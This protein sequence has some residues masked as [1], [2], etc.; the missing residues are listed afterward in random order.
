MSDT[1]EENVAVEQLLAER[2]ALHGW[3]QRLDAATVAAPAVVRE[4]VRRDYQQQ[5]D[6]VAD[7]LR[8]HVDAIA[9]KLAGD[10]AEHDELTLRTDASR[11]E[12]AEVELRHAVGEFSPERY[13]ADRKRHLSDL[14]AFELSVGAVAARIQRMDEVL[15]LVRRAPAT[16][17]NAVVNAP[18]T[19]QS[20]MSILDLAPADLPVAESA[21]QGETIESVE[22]VETVEAIDIDQLAAEAET[23]RVL[24]I[25]SSPADATPVG[26]TEPPATAVPGFGPLSFRPA[27]VVPT[28]E[29]TLIGL[30]GDSPPRFVRPGDRLPPSAPV[31]PAGQ[32][33]TPPSSSAP[34]TTTVPARVSPAKAGQGIFSEEIVAAGPAPSSPATPVGRTL[35]CGECGAMNRPLEWYC[36]KCGAELSA[37]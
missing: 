3:L 7:D 23:D 29:P 21:G 37:V 25:F 15:A 9:K 1:I 33:A 28:D 18:V 8:K 14:E 19:A 4:R 2:D 12:L 36:E 11:E 10:Q 17:G 6:R 20:E 30:P 32:T 34:A 5:L 16:S 26:A 31:R 13:E 24:S 35:R 22:V 27:G